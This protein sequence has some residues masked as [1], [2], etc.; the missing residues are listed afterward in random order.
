MLRKLVV[1]MEDKSQWVSGQFRV[2]H[3]KN[4]MIQ[5]SHLVLSDCDMVQACAHTEY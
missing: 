3:N 1:Y 2:Q 4:V 5:I